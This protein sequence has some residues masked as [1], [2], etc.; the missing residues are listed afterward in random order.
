MCGA[1]GSIA[2]VTKVHCLCDISCC[3]AMD[4]E[5][6]QGSFSWMETLIKFSV[7]LGKSTLRV[8]QVIEGRFRDTCS[9]IRNCL[10]MGKFH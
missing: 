6:L 3:L 10:P 1:S 2:A 4:R 7:L 9:F 5:R 8:L